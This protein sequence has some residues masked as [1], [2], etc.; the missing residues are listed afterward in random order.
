[1]TLKKELVVQLRGSAALQKG[2]LLQGLLLHALL[3]RLHLLVSQ[4]QTGESAKI[5]GTR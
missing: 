1:M 3:D 2:Q 5:R 4:R